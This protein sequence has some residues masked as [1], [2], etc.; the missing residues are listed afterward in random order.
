MRLFVVTAIVTFR[1]LFHWLQP[2]QYF[3]YRALFPLAQLSFFA[4]VGTYGGS[5]PLAF[6]LVGNVIGTATLSVFGVSQAVSDER[7]QGT[8]SYLLGSP[9]PR[10]PVFF[11][12]AVLHVVD[13]VVNMVFAVM[14]AVFVF[15]L[16]IPVE[17]LA[18][19]ALA[20]LVAT[21]AICG[22]GLLM[23][24]LALIVLDS[25]VLA[26]F[27]MFVILLLSGANVPLSELPG[28]V[29]AISEA[30]PLTRS[31]AAARLYANGASLDSGFAL[32]AGDLVVG[33]LYALAGFIVFT[34]LEETARRQG[35][36]EG[37]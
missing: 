9:A 31:I 7:Q 12:R 27:A 3:A 8:L 11:G 33:A 20:M 2:A 17:G 18:G 21:I 37:V 32:L 15:G 10:V 13:G 16:R 25:T 24:A 28:F 5:Q 4:L 34:W 22:F 29:A 30:M 6:Y 23:G 14:I 1:A 35:R 19:M 26:N 36:L